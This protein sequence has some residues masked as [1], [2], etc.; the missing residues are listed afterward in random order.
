ME[1]AAPRR[2]GAGKRRRLNGRQ[3]NLLLAG[4]LVALVV[5]GLVSWGVGTGWSQFWVSC[6]AVLGLALVLSLPR[7]TTTS[8]TTGMRRGRPSRWLSVVMG[9]AVVATVALGLAHSTGL[10][11]GVGEWSALWTHFLLAFALIPL[12]LWHYGSRPAPPRRADLDRRFVL[13]TGA[14]L[15]GGALTLG[16]LEAVTRLAGPGQRRFTGSREVGSFDPDAMPVV[17]WFDDTIPDLDREAWPLRIGGVE[18]DVA[19]L[20]ARATGIE[21]DLDCTGGW[22]SRQRWDAL[23]LADLFD[24]AELDSAR[25]ILVTSATGYRRLFPVAD[26]ATTLVALGYDG[27]PLRAGHGAPIRVVAPGRRGPWWVKWVTEIELSN[28]PWWVQLP[29]PAT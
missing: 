12:L 10:W 16:A 1:V 14:R 8:V 3:I 24:P 2:W 21:A 7:K 4:L 25:S 9:V 5:T 11:H 28:R 6:H 19:T 27:R 23:A 13:G 18:V 17:S 20:A 26:A 15:A 22:W 29:F